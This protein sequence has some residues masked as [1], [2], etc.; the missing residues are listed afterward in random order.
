MAIDHAAGL[1]TLDIVAAAQAN[2]L[3]RQVA[4]DRGLRSGPVPG[5]RARAARRARAA[6]TAHQSP[7]E[8]RSGR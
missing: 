2:D 5:L 4:L 8:G 6:P 3:M 7:G 1:F